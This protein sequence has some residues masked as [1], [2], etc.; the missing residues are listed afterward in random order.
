MVS[1]LNLLIGAIICRHGYGHGI[2]AGSAYLV[3]EY[4]PS[5]L[6]GLFAYRKQKL[7]LPEIKCTL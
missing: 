7:K 3:F 1:M 6:T 5:D 2:G 4:A